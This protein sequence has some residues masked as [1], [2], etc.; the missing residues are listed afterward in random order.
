VTTAGGEPTDADDDGPRDKQ[1]D[2]PSSD[3]DGPRRWGVFVV[4]AVVCL[5]GTFLVGLTDLTNTYRHDLSADSEFPA[6]ERLGYEELSPTGQEVFQTALDAEDAVW[7]AD[8]APDFSYPSEEGAWITR[9][10]YQGTT[11]RLSTQRQIR[12]ATITVTGI[13]LSLF[14]AGLLLL[15]AGGWPLLHHRVFDRSL[16]ARERRATTR[17]LPVWA[18]VFLVPALTSAVMGVLTLSETLTSS[19]DSFLLTSALFGIAVS[20]TSSVVVL[21][22]VRPDGR[23][24]FGSA[25]L[26]SL[27]WVFVLLVVLS[28][29]VVDI[30]SMLFLLTFVVLYSL[31]GELLGWNVWARLL[32][33]PE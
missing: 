13:R 27:C 12:G 24:F 25:V 33:P 26:G 16:S 17:L 18:F 32:A 2:A 6:D 29:S 10:E 31:L 1:R 22:A 11:Y 20:T 21:R 15:L 23:L 30:V 19:L 28:P 14:T 5:S 9:V 8:P 4:V 7:T 3:P